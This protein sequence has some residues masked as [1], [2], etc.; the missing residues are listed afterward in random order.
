MVWQQVKS[1]AV[2]IVCALFASACV[3]D[4]RGVDVSVETTFLV[5]GA[6][7]RPLE[8]TDPVNTPRV[9]RSKASV[10]L[11]GILFDTFDG[12]SISLDAI[13]NATIDRLLDAIAP[14]DAPDYQHPADAVWLAE[15][16]LIIGF[17]DPA[18][19]AW[20]YPARI[21]NFRE[22]VNDELGGLPVVVTY[23]PLCGSGVVYERTVA[24]RPLSFSNT[25]ALFEN[26]MVM[27]DRETGSYW[28]QVSG[29]AIVGELVSNQLVLLAS[30]TTTWSSWLGQH[31]DT[32]VMTRPA[33]GDFDR[34]PFENYSATLDTGA[35][36]FPV[37]EGVMDDDRLPSSA[38]V[39]I[40]SIHGESRAWATSPARTV[41]DVVAGRPVTVVADGVGASVLDDAGL[42]IPNRSA[43]WFAALTVDP[44]ITLGP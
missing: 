20:A 12:A 1:L 28:W 18:G 42:P 8:L 11:G 24:G 31:P 30:Q 19:A 5:P 13:D 35:T 6:A 2:I 7:T 26:D 43:F 27:V 32:L 25:S 22:I 3:A 4:E 34:N 37:S 40:V 14:I 15:D 23:C 17:V 36:P 39:V 38:R 16:D 44:D 41:H 33:G 29:D 21:L 9:D 10:S